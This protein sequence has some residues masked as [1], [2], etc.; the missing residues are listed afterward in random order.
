MSVD[1]M[2]EYRKAEIENALAKYKDTVL[3]LNLK[4]LRFVIDGVE[5]EPPPEDYPD[6]EIRD[7]KL[8]LLRDEYGIY[9]ESEEQP[10]PSL[11]D[12]LS[13][14]NREG[15]VASCSLDGVT[16]GDTDAAGREAWFSDLWDS[17]SNMDSA[18]NWPTALPEDLKYLSTLTP[19]ICGPGL[20]AYRDISQFSL[21]TDMSAM[22]EYEDHRVDV[23]LGQQR[24]DNNEF[25]ALSPAFEGW[26]IS[27]GAR[28]GD[29]PR[30]WGGGFVVFC[31]LPESDRDTWKWRY[32]MRDDTYSS[33]LFDTVEEFLGFYAHFNAQTE[34]DDNIEIVP[35]E[36]IL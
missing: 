2:D 22:D 8:Q 36:Q 6:D 16:H 21:L 15:L 17:I 10:V 1:T 4:A 11:H 33:E 20:P 26:D 9:L 13:E 28:I 34:E 25:N 30:A 12:L 35:L 24:M 5:E 27:V 29:G 14:D 18:E 19:G 7:L 23:P 32:G 31:R 3:D